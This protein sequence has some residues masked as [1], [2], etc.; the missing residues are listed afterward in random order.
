M[1][2]ALQAFHREGVPTVLV[3]HGYQV[4]ANKPSAVVR[5]YGT[6]L[7]LRTRFLCAPGEMYRRFY[8]SQ[9]V[10]LER[11]LVTGAYDWDVG[12][13]NASQRA[14]SLVRCALQP[15]RFTILYANSASSRGRVRAYAEE[16]HDEMVQSVGDLADAIGGAPDLQLVVR[17]HPDMALHEL[18]GDIASRYPNVVVTSQGTFADAL[19]ACDVLVT[20]CSSAGVQGLASDRPVVIYNRRGRMNNYTALLLDR[21]GCG[22]GFVLAAETPAELVP[23]FR[24]L[25]DDTKLRE[26]LAASRRRVDPLLHRDQRGA[27]ERIADALLTLA[28]DAR[29]PC[30]PPG[31]PCGGNFE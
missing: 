15:E 29:V 12:T 3:P 9:G 5:A 16:T 24:R 14:R 19:T 1:Q 11:V 6:M 2:W 30:S 22:D 18:F 4:V 17:P 8:A 7:K 25:R 27:A 31:Q 23:S 26:R 20:F 13:T 21:E 10:A 28:R